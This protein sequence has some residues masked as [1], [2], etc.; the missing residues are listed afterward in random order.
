[1]DSQSEPAGNESAAIRR[2]EAA[3]DIDVAFRRVPAIGQGWL[4]WYDLPYKMLGLAYRNPLKRILSE[5]IKEI[6]LDYRNYLLQYNVHQLNLARSAASRS[7][8]LRIVEP[9]VRVT[10]PCIWVVDL[11]PPSKLPA[12]ERALKRRA[13]N[14]RRPWAQASPNSALLSRFRTGSSLGWWTIVEIHDTKSPLPS[15][16]G[17]RAKL[18]AEFDYV[19]ISGLHIGSGLTAVIARFRTTE[20]GAESVDKVWHSN[21]RPSLIRE[22]GKSLNALDSQWSG[23]RR[24]REA[25]IDLHRVARNWLSEQCS[26]F[27][28][29]SKDQLV[30][31][32]LLLNQQNS[33]REE[34]ISDF[35]LRSI[36]VEARNSIIHSFAD[37]PGLEL[38]Q[39]ESDDFL[40]REREPTWSIWGFEK[41]LYSM[42]DRAELDGSRTRTI[43][44]RMHYSVAGLLVLLGISELLTSYTKRYAQLRDS[45]QAQHG[46]FNLGQIKRLRR[47]ILALSL[48]VASILNDVRQYHAVP[49]NV[50][51]EPQIREVPSPRRRKRQRVD[52]DS[53]TEPESFNAMVRKSQSEQAKRLAEIDNDYRGILSTVA[54]LG[55]AVDS[56]R[57]A[58][59]GRTIAI[60]SMIIAIATLL[61]TKIDPQSPL[62]SL[63]HWISQIR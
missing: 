40:D 31:D 34:I 52:D 49:P 63:F 44:H 2:T 55:S 15:N 6:V 23:L 36:G 50:F 28:G 29:E 21:H 10:M 43:A 42:L 39:F 12:L 38:E 22:R 25:R 24:T 1:M 16:D 3:D 62:I 35:A 37:F 33:T 53:G 9:H 11:F 4:R 58:R 61:V 17:I 41:H 19:E 32:L 60:S 5:R 18:P 45:A 27:L 8:R 14:R 51:G 7:S 56:S 57:L 47:D 59:A 46:R 26:G 54:A 13:W 30:A 20:S 48:D